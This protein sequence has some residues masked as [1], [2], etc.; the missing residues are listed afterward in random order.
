[1]GG[2]PPRH[3]ETMLSGCEALVLECYH[4]PALLAAGPYPTWLKTRIGGRFGHLANA[5]AAA[6]L[7]ALDRSR[8]RHI[9]A[10]HLSRTNNRPELATGAL[11]PV[12]GCAAG[13][14]LVADQARGFGWLD[15]R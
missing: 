4:D 10:A 12:L 13:E 15:M 14:I 11:A 7:G 8:L 5:A 9:V 2:A 1:V 6:L 3:I